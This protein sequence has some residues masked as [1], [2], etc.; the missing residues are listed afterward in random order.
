MIQF[1]EK[2][3][4]LRK[5][6]GITQERLAQELHITRQAISKWESDITQPDLEN[7]VKTC[8]FFEIS[9]DELLDMDFLRSDKK[10]TD[11]MGIYIQ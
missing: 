6:K 8:T 2:L 3:K 4:K 10:K 11:T 7:I 9:A 1:G 5:K